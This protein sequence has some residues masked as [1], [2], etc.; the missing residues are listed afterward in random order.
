MITNLFV[1]GQLTTSFQR[2]LGLNKVVNYR[3]NNDFKRLCFLNSYR[4]YIISRFISLYLEYRID[5]IV[6]L[7]YTSYILQLLDIDIFRPLKRALSTKVDRLLRL[8]TSNLI[9]RIDRSLY[10]ALTPNN[11]KSVF[12]ASRIR[13]LLLIIILSAL[14]IPSGTP[15]KT[16]SIPESLKD[17]NRSLIDKKTP[18]STRDGLPNL[19]RSLRSRILP[20]QLRGIS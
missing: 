12:R 3:L 10:K 2:I 1:Y 14:R 11:V 16:L 17:L 20:L 6:L 15:P 4:S 13:P 5:F 18:K 9:R 8:D 7:L 19:I